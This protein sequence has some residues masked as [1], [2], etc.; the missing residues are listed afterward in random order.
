M[1]YCHVRRYE[2]EFRDDLVL[3]AKRSNLQQRG[4]YFIVDE[5]QSRLAYRFR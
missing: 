2:L 4:L 5:A 3:R 1:N